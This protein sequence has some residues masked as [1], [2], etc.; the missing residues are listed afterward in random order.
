[1]PIKIFEPT[2]NI[3]RLVDLWSFAPLY[4]KKAG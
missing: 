4:L 2:S 3:Q 1:L